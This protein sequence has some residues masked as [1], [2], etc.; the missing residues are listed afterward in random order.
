MKYTEIQNKVASDLNIPLR[1]AVLICGE[2]RA[3]ETVKMNVLTV[4]ASWDNDGN[5]VLDYSVMEPV[6]RQFKP[7]KYNQ[8]NKRK[9]MEN[10]IYTSN[11]TEYVRLVTD[12]ESIVFTNITKCANYCRNHKIEVIVSNIILTDEDICIPNEQSQ[13]GGLK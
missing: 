11:Q 7:I 9:S 3:K 1:D 13:E 8:Q 5:V 12:T 4:E 6:K 2:F 10:K